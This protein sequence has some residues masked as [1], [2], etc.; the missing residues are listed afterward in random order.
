MSCEV[1][2]WRNAKKMDPDVQIH[3][4]TAWL[5]ELFILPTLL[6]S[7]IFSILYP[8]SAVGSAT[9]EEEKKKK[10]ISLLA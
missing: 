4:L 1:T 2:D 8:L 3:R 10:K 6:F 5:T 7:L 9:E